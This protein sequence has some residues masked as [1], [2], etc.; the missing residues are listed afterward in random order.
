M[1]E[2]DFHEIQEKILKQ[3]GYE[4]KEKSFSEIRGNI[5]SNKFSFHLNKLQEKD[6]IEKNPEGYTLTKKGR[7]ILPYFDLEEKYHPVIVVDLLV[8]HE[9]K[10]YLRPKEEDPLDPF[11]G[12]YRAPSKRLGKNDRL[13][14]KAADLFK[15]EFGENPEKLE[16]AAVFDS[17]VSF[18]DNSKQHYILFY[19]KTNVDEKIGDKW[20]KIDKLEDLNLLPGLEKV[21]K[22]LRENSEPKI[23]RWDIQEE[24]GEFEI[25]ELD[26]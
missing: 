3:L 26:F 18:K 8:Y 13:E 5:E 2:P 12:E 15:Q 10:I 7:E 1:K 20:F 14:E 9:D 11:S 6:L 22:E 19:F 16:K 25:K 17:E 21:V 24:N 23:G 4:N